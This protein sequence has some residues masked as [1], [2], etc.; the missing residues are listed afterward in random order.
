MDHVD[1]VARTIW[2]EARGTSRA[3]MQRVANVIANRAHNPRWWGQDWVGVCLAAAQFSCWNLDDPNRPKLLEV[4][5]SDPQ[6]QTAV[7]LAASAVAGTLPDLTGN[8]DHYFFK[9]SQSPSW[10]VA[11]SHTITDEWHSFY[12]LELPPPVKP[13]EVPMPTI[14]TM[15]PSNSVVT[16]S[17]LNASTTQGTAGLAAGASSALVI[18]IS[19]VMQHYGTA[20]SLEEA[21]AMTTLLGLLLHPLSVLLVGNDQ[22]VPALPK[23]TPPPTPV[24]VDPHETGP[25]T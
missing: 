24:V 12:R 20:P 3:G 10:A 23:P 4:T 16:S 5:D 8:A 15:P 11:A 6:F 17:S 2:G 19:G 25:L 22:A 14:P 13:I 18:L 1:T 21:A 9:T 7:E